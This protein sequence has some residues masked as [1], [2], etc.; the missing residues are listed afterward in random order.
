[1]AASADSESMALITWSDRMSVG[2]E[3]IDKQHRQLIDLLN[4]LHAEMMAGR[5][6]QAVSEVL[7]NLIKYAKTHFATEETLF[8]NHGYPQS[9]AHK[10]EHDELT[11]KAIALQREVSSGRA[12]LTLP[13]MN[14]LKDWLSSHILKSDMAYRPF[15]AAKGIK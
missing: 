9:Q 13:T 2:V 14:F 3:R 4:S 11:D 5:G 7:D 10:Q 6:L 8:R 12:T 1:M 15:F